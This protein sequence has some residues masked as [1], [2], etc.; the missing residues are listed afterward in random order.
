MFPDDLIPLPALPRAVAAMTGQPAPSYHQL[1]LAAVAGRF[2]AEQ[3]RGRWRVQR[4][5]LPAIA[6]ALGASLPADTDNQATT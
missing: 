3:V 2:P 1:Y 4:A 6:R 5:D